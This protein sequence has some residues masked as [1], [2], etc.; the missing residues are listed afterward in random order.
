MS[1]ILFREKLKKYAYEYLGKPYKYGAKPYHAPKEFDCSSF[2]QFSYRKIGIELP[3]TSIHQAELGNK[4]EVDEKSLEIGDLIFIHGI[5]G[6]YS[7]KF[8]KGIGHVGMYVGAGEVINARWKK[9]TEGTDGGVVVKQ[10]LE[11]YI[12]NQ[13]YVIAKRIL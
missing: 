8:P 11:E 3:R 2:V 6:R 10:P 7:T 1:C 5:S 13:E 9:N 4:I 12:C